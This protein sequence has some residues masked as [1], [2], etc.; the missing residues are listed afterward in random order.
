MPC[1]T[2]RPGGISNMT[3][4]EGGDALALVPLPFVT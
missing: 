1:R 2:R 3:D 4:R